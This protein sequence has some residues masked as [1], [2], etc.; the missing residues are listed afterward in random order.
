[1]RVAKR[2]PQPKAFFAAV[3]SV[4]LAAILF[5]ET[6]EHPGALRS[7]L[8]APEGTRFDFSAGPM[9]LSPDGRLLAFVGPGP[10]GKNLLWL[11]RIDGSAA[12]PLAG[13]EMASNPFWS[14]DGRFLAFFARG[15]L[16]KV[17]SRRGTPAVICNAENGLGG[18]WNSEGTILFAPGP[19]GPILR[20][21][22]AGGNPTPSHAARSGAA[23]DQPPLAVLSAGRTSFPVTR[24]CGS[25]PLPTAKRFPT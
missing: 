16:M 1:L 13:T 3:I 10:A 5:S 22:S 9:A 7:P 25:C 20:V 2:P 24:T 8:T 21:S 18:T 19:R 6:R 11:R 12:R 15:K 4:A 23:A 14:P 17:R